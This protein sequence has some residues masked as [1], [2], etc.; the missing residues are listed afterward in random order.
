MSSIHDDTDDDM[1]M[2]SKL[3]INK[4]IM[5]FDDRK[6]KKHHSFFLFICSEKAKRRFN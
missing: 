4:P 2:A 5:S 1:V 3:I 6:M